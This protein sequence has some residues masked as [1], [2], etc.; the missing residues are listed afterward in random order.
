MKKSLWIKKKSKFKAK[1]KPSKLPKPKAWSLKRA[2]DEFSLWIRQRDGGC[3]YPGCQVK[4]IKKLQNSHYVGRAHKATAFL[5]ENCI[6]LCGKHHFFDKLIGFEYQKQTKE[7][8]GYDGQY[9]LF[10]KE[11]LGVARFEAL[12]ALG[13]TVKKQYDAILE[14]MRLVKNGKIN[15]E[16]EPLQPND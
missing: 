9:T 3:R 7:G 13:R 16:P 6:S 11:W 14:C 2:H 5:P 12:C 4:D 8:Q 10:M 1:R 15:K